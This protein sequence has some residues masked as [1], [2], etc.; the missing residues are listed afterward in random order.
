MSGKR[1]TDAEL[2]AEAEANRLKYRERIA[3]AR[4]PDIRAIRKAH[5]V[6]RR[7][8]TTMHAA[9]FLGTAID[10]QSVAE[11]LIATAMGDAKDD[12]ETPDVDDI[13][14]LESLLGHE[15]KEAKP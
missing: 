15:A 2:L 12:A 7:R 14:E 13:D 4:D 8:G 3:T 10:L 9:L 5:E 11:K 6:C 1:R